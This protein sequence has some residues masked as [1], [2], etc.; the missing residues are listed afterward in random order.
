MQ[1]ALKYGLSARLQH[2]GKDLRP[3]FRNSHWFRDLTD[4]LPAFEKS[5]ESTLDDAV[6]LFKDQDPLANVRRVHVPA[7]PRKEA[8]VTGPLTGHDRKWQT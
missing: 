6:V 1:L 5:E 8:V 7:E 4:P 2:L 3:E